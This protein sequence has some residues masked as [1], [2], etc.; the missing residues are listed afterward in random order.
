MTSAHLLRAAKIAGLLAVTVGGVLVGLMLAAATKVEVG[1]FTST[2]TVAPSIVG[3][4]EVLIP[5][6]GSLH[7]D[8]HEGPAHLRVRLDGLDRT[9]TEALITDPASITRASKGAVEDVRVG[10]DRLIMRATAVGML[11][12]MLAA[13]VIYRRMRQVAWAGGLALVIMAAGFGTAGLS[14]NPAAL[15]EPRYDGLLANAPAVIG[16]VQRIADNYDEY[17]R[18]LEK[19]VI[20]VGS[21]YDTVS[22]L[23]IYTPGDGTTRVLHVSDLHLNPAAWPMIR[24]VVEQF[25][26]NVVVD[27]G[28]IN[29]WGSEVEA[30]FVASIALLEVPYVYVR[31]NHDSAVTQAAV[32]AQPNAIVLDNTVQTVAGLTFAG[33]GDPRFSPDKEENPYSTAGPSQQ[34]V[35]SVVDTGK[36]LASTITASPAKV[37]VALVHDPLAAEQLAGTCP[38][39]LAGHRH[40]RAVAMLPGDTRLMVQGSTGGAGLRGL[41]GEH[42]E[43]LAMSVLYFD[44]EHQLVA[45]D[46]I[47]V[48]GTGLAEVSLKRTT[49]DRPKPAVSPSGSPSP[50][51]TPAPSPS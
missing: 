42:P 39:V 2:F 28:D 51:G 16:D 37:D 19:M 20:N 11:G 7:L 4:T 38:L 41:E 31:G 5:P 26:I 30:N 21:L 6:L 15:K 48:G 1:P 45:Y 44:P 22:N 49:I 32:A 47:T 40:E 43:P 3:D 9:R 13:A 36:I 24:S 34:S 23:P 10:V 27:T 50:S 18:Q 8:T 46:D 25:H 33:I 12:A 17:A 35:T 14:F 29:D